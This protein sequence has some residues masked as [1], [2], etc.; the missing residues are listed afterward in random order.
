MKTQSI[1]RRN[2]R[3]DQIQ[4]SINTLVLAIRFVSIIIGSAFASAAFII[5]IMVISYGPTDFAARW[6]F[7]LETL[8]KYGYI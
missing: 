5:G 8:A 6:N 2:A 4:A 1:T 7:V 3:L